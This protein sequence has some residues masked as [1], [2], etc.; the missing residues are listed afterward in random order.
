MFD[1]LKSNRRNVL[2]QIDHLKSILD[3]FKDRLQTEKDQELLDMMELAAAIKGQ[4]T[5]GEV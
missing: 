2:E 3:E 1:V 5:Q 4:N